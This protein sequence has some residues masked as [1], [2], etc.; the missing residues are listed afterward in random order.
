M[1]KQIAYEATECPICFDEFVGECNKIVTECGHKFHYTCLTKYTE[2]NTG[3]GCPSCRAKLPFASATHAPIIAPVIAPPIITEPRIAP[4]IAAPRICEPP[5]R[6]Y[7]TCFGLYYDY[8]EYSE[9]E[10][11]QSLKQSLKQKA[12]LSQK[13]AEME[14]NRVTAI[15]TRILNA[16]ENKLNKGYKEFKRAQELANFAQKRALADADCALAYSLADDEPEE[17]IEL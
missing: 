7:N 11:Q 8:S 6:I 16:P 14:T 12:A 15:A 5:L 9:Y 4:V 10:K 2:T 13:R 17:V 1:S 3:T